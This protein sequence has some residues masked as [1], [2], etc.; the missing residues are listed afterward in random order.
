MWPEEGRPKTRCGEGVLGA[1]GKDA[2]DRTER[3]Q[4]GT[5][6]SE[7]TWECLWALELEEPMFTAH[8]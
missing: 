2:K 8:L 3:K 5:E 4:W 1:G 6:G 7:Q